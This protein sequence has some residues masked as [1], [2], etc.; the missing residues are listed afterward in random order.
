MRI[1]F[2][3]LALLSASLPAFG[4]V[5]GAYHHRFALEGDFLLWRL[6]KSAGKSLVEA[7][8]GPPNELIPINGLIPLTPSKCAKEPGKTLISSRNLVND[9]HFEPGVR[10]SAKL[11]Y[12]IHS[13]WVL[14]YTGF[15][16][17][18]GQDKIHCHRNLNLPG[19]LGQNSK[20]YHYADRARAIYLSDFYTVDLTYWRHV[21]PRYTDHFSVSWMIGLR[22]FDID[23]KIKL[24]FTKR[25]RTSSYR[26]KTYDRAFGPFF[27]GSIEYNPYRFLTWG[28]AG[29]IGGVFNRGKQKTL[30]RDDNNTVVVRDVD[31]S[32]SNFGYFAYVY[33]FIEFPFVKFFTFRIGYDMLYI[34]RVALADDQLVFHGTGNHLNHDGNIIYHGLFAGMQFNF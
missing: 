6:A 21:T 8:G 22:F 5:K 14:S 32:G 29:N 33:P 30:M 10:I 23:E 16:N 20:D 19:E 25:H 11:F 26:V 28:I 31:P 17:W 24:Y 7:A 3:C 15:L 27:G 4:A 13:T 34:G 9:M 12:S 18:K 1:I 2:L